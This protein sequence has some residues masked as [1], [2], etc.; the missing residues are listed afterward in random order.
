[1]DFRMM[2][3]PNDP[4][5]LPER[6]IQ[7]IDPRRAWSSGLAAG[8]L[9]LFALV[10]RGSILVFTPEALQADPDGYRAVAENLVRHGTFGSRQ[11][12]TA[13][14]PPLYP[15]VLAACV[16]LGPAS[17]VAIGLLHLAL[18]LG[19]VWLTYRLGQ[20]CGLGRWAGLAAVLVACDPILLAQSTL[21]MTETLATFL[22]VAALE[23]LA[24]TSERHS[25]RWAIVAG[26]VVGL[27]VLC[28]P[29]FLPWAIVVPFALLAVGQRSSLPKHRAFVLAAVFAAALVAVVAPWAIRNQFQFGRPIVTTTHG[30]YTLL[31]ANNPDFYQYLRS[32]PWGTVWENKELDRVWAAKAPRGTPADEIHA[33]RL[34]YAEAVQSIRSEPAM[35][36]YACLVRVGR[37]F[38]F[39]PHQRSPDEGTLRR[40]IRYGVGAWYLVELGLAVLGALIV[41]VNAR[42]L[43]TK[44]FGWIASLLLAACFAALHAVYWTDMRMRAPLMPTVALSAA[45]GVG[46]LA[47]R[48]LHRK[49]LQPKALGM[50]SS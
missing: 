25:A 3:T 20:S 36:C 38:S 5:L 10:L 48:A 14:R 33:D 42:R 11:S 37:L 50:P 9:L 28:R 16:S 6:Q 17:R 29:T 26:G 44:H 1:V 21:V 19:T 41:C 40:W 30:G 39:L 46:W 12:P 49:S 18:G 35:F 45:L 34:A 15:C 47:G 31:L 22:A 27:C 24:M 23:C 8:G 7:L 13:Y 2:D 4:E 32:T 43:R